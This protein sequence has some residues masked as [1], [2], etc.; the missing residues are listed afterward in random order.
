MADPAD[1]VMQLIFGASALGIGHWLAIL[2]ASVA[3][4]LVVE[5]EKWVLRQRAHPRGRTRDPAEDG[6]E[7]AKTG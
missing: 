1:V 5:L 6:R 4:Y 7:H 3:I 2:S